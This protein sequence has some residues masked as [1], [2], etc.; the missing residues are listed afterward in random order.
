MTADAP[1]YER[2]ALG[3]TASPYVDPLL[4]QGRWD[5]P[6][7]AFGAVT[8]TRAFR[9]RAALGGAFVQV[10]HAGVGEIGP[11]R[12]LVGF[13]TVIATPAVPAARFPAFRA[14]AGLAMPLDGPR[15]RDPV[16]FTTLVLT[17]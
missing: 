8:G 1:V 6:G 11:G 2:F 4:L 12:R 7:Q 14:K 17:P 3:G 16:F 13:E 15:R 5:A 9:A 10:D